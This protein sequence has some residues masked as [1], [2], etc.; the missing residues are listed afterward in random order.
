MMHAAM[1]MDTMI[2]DAEPSAL[3]YFHTFK[4]VLVISQS[5]SR[6][7]VSMQHRVDQWDLC[8]PSLAIPHLQESQRMLR[9]NQRQ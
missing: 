8:R 1:I 6:M 4:S 2:P 9:L 3:I 5:A 7:V